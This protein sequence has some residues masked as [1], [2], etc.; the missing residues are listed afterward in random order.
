M[1]GSNIA[2]NC[3]LQQKKFNN[4]CYDENWENW[5]RDIK[6]NMLDFENFN[7]ADLFGYATSTRGST[8]QFVKEWWQQTQL[9]FPDIK[10]RDA[11]IQHQELMVKRGESQ[12]DIQQNR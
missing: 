3:Q 11:L 8:I 2:Y 1:Y 7:P 12:I 10:K 5:L 9:G 6:N 4:N